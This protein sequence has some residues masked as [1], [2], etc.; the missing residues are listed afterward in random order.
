[1]FLRTKSREQFLIVK[2]IFLIF[3]FV[4]QKPVFKSSYDFP[5][6]IFI[7]NISSRHT[8]KCILKAGY[9]YKFIKNLFQEDNYFISIKK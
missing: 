4:K 1:M 6:N 5:K 2:R 8:A 3:C 7:K 9:I